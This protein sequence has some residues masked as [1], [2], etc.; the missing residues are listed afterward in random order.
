[1]VNVAGRST[2]PPPARKKPFPHVKEAIKTTLKGFKGTDRGQL[3]M[4]C[5][6]GKTLA[7]M[8]DRP[9]QDS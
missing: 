4:A 7:A 1:V 8:C 6:T 3:L 5:G 2:R 9:G